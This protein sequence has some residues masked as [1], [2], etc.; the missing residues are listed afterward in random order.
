M[1]VNYESL[2]AWVRGEREWR[3]ADEV[4]G[5]LSEHEY[6]EL[7]R[8]RKEVADLEVEREIHRKAAAAYFAKETTR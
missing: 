3:A 1:G 5:A 8:L 6:L 4:P 2:G 7:H